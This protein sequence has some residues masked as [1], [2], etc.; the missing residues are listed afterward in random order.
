MP[1]YEYKCPQCGAIREV[2]VSLDEKVRLYHCGYEVMKKI[3]SKPAIHFSGSGFY[4]TDYKG[5]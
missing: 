3:I 2:K 5:K 4:E 1:I